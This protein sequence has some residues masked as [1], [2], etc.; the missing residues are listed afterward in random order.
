M[1]FAAAMLGLVEF[2][3]AKVEWRKSSPLSHDL[4]VII[5][6]LV[7]ITMV[8]VLWA[9]FIRKRERRNRALYTR[10]VNHSS[11]S[12]SVN[13]ANSDSDH[14]PHKRRKRRRRRDHRPRNPTL[15]ET[16]GLPPIRTDGSRPSVL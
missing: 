7:V 8:L 9:V 11:G 16:G 1:I 3:D 14:G 4:A 5:T 12:K 15:A 13:G 2:P 10:P 6:T